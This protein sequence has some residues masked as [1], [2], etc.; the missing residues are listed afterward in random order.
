VAKGLHRHSC[1][2]AVIFICGKEILQTE[3]KTQKQG[4]S[5]MSK[6]HDLSCTNFL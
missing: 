6:E 4:N 1:Y 3:E 2:D 5:R